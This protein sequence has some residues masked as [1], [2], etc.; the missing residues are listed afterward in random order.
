MAR[1]TPPHVVILAGGAGAR[2]KIGHPKA[3]HPVFFRPM[4]HYALDAARALGPPSTRLVVGPGER[5]FREQCRSWPEV[6]IVRQEEERGPA[7]AVRAAG[8]APEPEGDVLILTADAPLLTARTLQELAARR[9]EA[10]AACAV[11]R[12]AEGGGEAVAWCFRARDLA[13]ALTGADILVP[14]GAAELRPA[15]PVETLGV[16]DLY[17]LWRAEAVLQARFN[18]ALMLGGT[19]LQ[20]PGTTLIDPRCRIERGV[21]VEGGCTVINSVLEAGARLEAYCR[22]EDSVIGAGSRLLQGTVAREARV[23]RDCRVGP[24]AHLRPGAV[25]EDD[26]WVGNYAELKNAVLGAGTRAAHQCYVG[27]A[28]V[29]RRAVI[30][31]G[32][33]TCG[34]GA[35]A[36]KQRTVIEDDVFVGGASHALA[37]VR[38]GAGSFV[39]TGT[40]VTEDVPPDSFVISR[41]RQVVK[42]GY[43]KKYGKAKDSGAPR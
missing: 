7:D 23:G 33:V 39:A 37:P 4:I 10:D 40:S 26:V 29:G 35:G 25:L 2:M 16:D 15:D 19:A 28:R 31:G 30:G 27:D 21:R 8:P 38:V 9:A 1:L 42:A 11:V 13:A 18:R 3:L 32:F 36:P 17:G 14:E 22:I 24:Y 6:R 41:A 5:E 12:G 34:S 43:S 20:D